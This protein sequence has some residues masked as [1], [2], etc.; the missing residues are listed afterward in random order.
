MGRPPTL[1]NELLHLLSTFD[2]GDFFEYG[3]LPLS[4]TVLSELTNRSVSQVS[5]ALRLMET[6]GLVTSEVVVKDVWNAIARS[7]LPRKTK[8]YW[9][10]ENAEVKEAQV[11]A[12][13]AQVS[14]GEERALV[15][16]EVFHVHKS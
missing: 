14:G 5:H 1:Q 15:L 16:A 3:V 2:S 13:H 10:T 11:E 8:A 6:R 4:A 7:H 9:A 12:Y